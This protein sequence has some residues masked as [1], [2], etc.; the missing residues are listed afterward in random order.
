MNTYL[1]LVFVFVLGLCRHTMEVI[2]NA[3]VVS[4]STAHRTT[5]FFP[6]GTNAVNVAHSLLATHITTFHDRVRI[7]RRIAKCQDIFLD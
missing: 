3:R 7:I 4:S 5:I 1:N 6:T 2:A